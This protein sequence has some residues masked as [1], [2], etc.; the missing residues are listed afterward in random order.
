MED[1]E[2]VEG[3]KAVISV[4]FCQAIERRQ[5][6]EDQLKIALADN[7]K[8]LE[9]LRSLAE[10]K[11]LSAS[12]T[13]TASAKK[14]LEEVLK[15]AK[16]EVEKAKRMW[17]SLKSLIESTVRICYKSAAVILSRPFFSSHFI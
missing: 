3:L 10:K 13:G 4:T 2:E 16:E 15:E 14:K 12:K 1:V 9:K 7:G 6:I 8:C 5:Q 17:N 11:Q